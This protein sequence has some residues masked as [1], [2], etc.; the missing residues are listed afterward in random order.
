MTSVSEM[1]LRRSLVE[2]CRGMQQKGLAKGTSGNVS[3][4][5]A[6]GFL[7]SPTGVSY[8]T[9]EPEQVVRMRWDGSFDGDMLP[10]SEW[11]FHRDILD[12]RAD[13]NAIVHTHSM[14][15][16]AVSILGHEIPP[17]HYRIAAAGG[18]N[19]R[20][21]GYATFGTQQLADLAVAAMEGRRAC[22]LAHH[23]AIAAHASLAG[24]LSVAEV[25]EELATLYLLC[26]PIG[27]PPRLSPEAIAE[28]IEKHKTY[29]QQKPLPQC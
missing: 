2:T 12:R 5:V 28:V 3:V 1:E 27:N 10:S 22:L 4:R 9:L 25:V 20:C 26:L 6:D 7:I 18:P 29:G 15:A 21:A 13:L 24:A 8:G 16:T 14:N 11:R 23:G 17:I 19:I